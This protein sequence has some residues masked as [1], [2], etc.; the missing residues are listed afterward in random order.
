MRL[1]LQAQNRD[2]QHVTVAAFQWMPEETREALVRELSLTGCEDQTYP[3]V[4]T[5]PGGPAFLVYYWPAVL[6]HCAEEHC[7]SAA[8]HFLVEIFRAARK[9]WPLSPSEGGRNVTLLVGELKGHTPYDVAKGHANGQCWVLERQ[10]SNT[11]VVAKMEFSALAALGTSRREKIELLEF[12]HAPALAHCKT[13]DDA[14]TE[15][16]LVELKKRAQA[17]LNQ[18]MTYGDVASRRSIIDRSAATEIAVKSA[19]EQ[20]KRVVSSRDSKCSAR[21]ESLAG[22]PASSE[23]AACEDAGVKRVVRDCSPVIEQPGSAVNRN[24]GLRHMKFRDKGAARDGVK[25]AD[26]A[27]THLDLDA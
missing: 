2:E 17:V 19:A 16:P 20:F 18:F 14:A 27:E 13:H 24:R 23:T 3:G 12:W 7:A 22:G 9:F 10:A 6:R 26:R 1:V 21:T 5:P 25:G 4:S 8:L 11:G 15:F